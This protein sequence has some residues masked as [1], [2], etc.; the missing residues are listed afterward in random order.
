MQVSK[1][2]TENTESGRFTMMDQTVT[3][4]LDMVDVVADLVVCR[5]YV[6]GGSLMRLS[7]TSAK[8]Q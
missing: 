8:I 6:C 7:E 1:D 2:T 5:T 4:K 3:N